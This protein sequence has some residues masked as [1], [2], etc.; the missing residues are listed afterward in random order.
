MSEELRERLARWYFARYGAAYRHDPVM[1]G[2]ALR[3]VDD[4]LT[5][6]GKTHWMVVI[7]DDKSGKLVRCEYEHDY[8]T[9]E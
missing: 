9:F 7:G 5:E 2:R 3:E 8:I 1:R 4:I 6:I